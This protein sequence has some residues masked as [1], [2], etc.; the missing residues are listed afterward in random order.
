MPPHHLLPPPLGAAGIAHTRTREPVPAH[1]LEPT[2]VHKR[3]HAKPWSHAGW[4]LP[5]L[6]LLTLLG[7]AP[8]F[9]YDYGREILI[10][11]E[12]D[13]YEL[14][15]LGD[16]S[17]AETEQLLAMLKRKLELNTASAETL[18]NLP[19]VSVELARAMVTYRQ[20]TPFEKLEDVLRV[21][22]M[23]ENIL[24]Q[25]RPF[26]VVRPKP[27]KKLEGKA[28]WKGTL[29]ARLAWAGGDEGTP[30][31]LDE[32]HEQGGSYYP[33][34]LGLDRL[35][36][37]W[38][39]LE[40]QGL[41]KVQA[42][43]L[44]TAGEGMA[45]FSFDA[46][47][48]ELNATWGRP[49]FGLRKLYVQYDDPR[50]QVLLGSFSAGFG[51]GLVFNNA[52]KDD[53]NGFEADTEV[54]GSEDFSVPQ[55]LFGVAAS[56]SAPLLGKTRVELTAFLSQQSHDL[57]QYDF[58]LPERVQDDLEATTAPVLLE[59][60][61]LIASTLPNAYLERTVGVHA[62]AILDKYN[63]LGVTAY[64][65]GV[66][67]NFEFEFRNSLP[68]RAGF[69]ALG[70][71]FGAALWKTRLKGELAIMD[72]QS[73]AFTL[74]GTQDFGKAE[75]IARVYGYGEDFDNPH[76][77]GFADA[78]Q[79]GG[80]RDRDEVGFWT[81]AAWK[82]I[83]PLTLR[84]T[85]QPFYRPSIDAWRLSSEARVD[86]AFTKRYNLGT[87]WTY[88]DKD[89]LLGG[90]S[91]SYTNGSDDS[92]STLAE[93]ED[94]TLYVPPSSGDEPT[95]ARMTAALVGKA[96]PLNGLS[97]DLLVKRL[98]ED[99]AYRY[100]AADCTYEYG[101][102]IGQDTSIKARYAPSDIGFATARLRLLDEDVYGDL[103][104]HLFTGYA[105]W[106]QRLK[107]G[108]L[109]GRYGVEIPLADAPMGVTTYCETTSGDDCPPG[110]ST[111]DTTTASDESLLPR[112]LFLATFEAR[113]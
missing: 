25:L 46:A 108:Q 80:K 30:L 5:T 101:W 79:F 17:E 70:V 89:L 39:R 93:E 42:G 54:Y 75:V 72:N 57:Y 106:T 35:P 3:A 51:Q 38:L 68:T 58:Y 102:M 29:E 41:G 18:F 110:T 88:K 95:G 13:I 97:I 4:V 82:P 64:Y 21:P 48:Q 22:G 20:I 32:A 15:N 40:G 37:T 9:A 84:A 28:P 74:E 67:K 92:D 55:R 12:E 86:Y 69:G 61:P 78:D 76:S 113:F 56:A 43:L 10:D 53:L 59:G 44:T 60:V 73:L 90:R 16:L 31:S 104:E 1:T 105:Q 109:S 100:Y 2:S 77:R 8:A 66:E 81:R 99:A 62:Q 85:L 50:Y 63:W 36:E 83:K 87:W 7:S 71:H 65:S 34:E 94:G 49:L 96:N 91:R 11:S 19:G 111:S 103:G 52:R 45:R 26:G 33:S 98:Y 24:S 107:W 23:T 112:H 6:L 47:Q 27:V 14:Y